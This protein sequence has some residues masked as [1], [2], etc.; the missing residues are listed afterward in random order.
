VRNSSTR[1]QK[2][3]PGWLKTVTDLAIARASLDPVWTDSAAPGE[4]IAL[5][6]GKVPRSGDVRPNARVR[7]AI[8]DVPSL[9]ARRHKPAPLQTRQMVG[10]AAAGCADDRREVC[11]SALSTEQNLQ[12]VKPGGVPKN[13][14]VPRPG[15]QGRTWRNCTAVRDRSHI[16]DTDRFSCYSQTRRRRPFVTKWLLT[17]YLHRVLDA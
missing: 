15:R 8:E 14:K 3:Q 5:P 17:F 10:D 2:I 7:H 11:D 13:P 12:H 9:P 4:V 6:G 1:L 16:F